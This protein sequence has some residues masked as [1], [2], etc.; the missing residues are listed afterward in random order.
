VKAAWPEVESA[1]FRDN[2]HIGAICEHLQAVT[3]GQIP[4]LLLNIPPACSKSLLVSVFWPMW[5]WV[6]DPTVRWFFASYDLS[7]SVRDSVKCRRLLGSDW[8]KERWGQCVRLKGDQN[9]KTYYETDQGGYR[10][11]TSIGGH[12]TGEHPDR[13]VVDDPHDVKGAVSDTER[14]A[15]LTWW[16]QTMATR[17]MTRK[18]RQV[19]VMQRLHVHDLSG[20]VL[21]QGGFTHI[22]LPMRF[23]HGR[24]A[25]TP[26]DWNDSRKEE[27][28]LL[29]PH[30]LTEEMVRDKEKQLGTYGTASQFQQRPVPRSGGMFKQEWF[31]DKVVEAAPKQAIRVR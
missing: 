9:Q 24:M 4:K 26:L 1:P 5:E 17:G 7:L 19:I 18:A 31:A 16:D 10:L 21:S 23:E 3:A 20:H 25:T 22:C 8:F 6:E 13:I 15:V 12:G 11:A 29:A 30:Y 28:E 2:W 27:G 14:E